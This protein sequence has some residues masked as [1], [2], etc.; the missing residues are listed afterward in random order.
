MA[1]I[2]GERAAFDG[3]GGMGGISR[4]GELVIDWDLMMGNSWWLCF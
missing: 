4:E 2:N 1:T 3:G